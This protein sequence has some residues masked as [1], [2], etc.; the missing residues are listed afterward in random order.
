MRSA[1]ARELLKRPKCFALLALIAQRAR[2]TGE[3]NLHDLNVGEALIGDHKTVGLT[4]QEY[5]T[6][7]KTLERL[8]LAT[9][10]GTSKGTVACLI[11][12][13]V[14]DINA[15]VS[16]DRV[17]GRATSKQ[18]ANNEMATTNKNEKKKKGS[19]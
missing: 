16:S 3:I 9:F 14:F 10:T 13:S 11:D 5:R 19:S 7:K 2:R 15:E 8:R 17:N 1:N 12:K 18:R 6:A 4:Q